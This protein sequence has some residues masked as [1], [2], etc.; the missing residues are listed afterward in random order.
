[1]QD[2]AI[3]RLN[4][5]PLLAKEGPGVLGGSP[6]NPE[7][8]ILNPASGVALLAVMSA[9]SVMIIVA[10]TFSNSVQIETRTAI[11]RKEAAQAYALAVGGV[12]AAI[13]EIAYPPPAE[14]RDAPRLWKE[15]QLVMQ[16]PYQRGTA[17]VQIVNE[18]GKLDL[19]LASR[20]Q[21]ARLFQARGLEAV[22]A[23]QLALAIDH[24]RAPA[25]AENQD[26]TALEDYYRAAG[27]RPAHARFSSVEEAL[28]LRGMARDFFYGTAL[29][30][31]G[32]GIRYEYGVGQ[33]LTIYS[34]AAQ[35]NLNYA[36]EAVLLSLPG[37]TANLV[38]SLLRE[39]AGEPFR[40]LDDV[41]QR[42]GESLPDSA[43]AFLTTQS[44]QTYSILSV[45]V[46]KGSRLRRSVR[47]VVRA[48]PEEGGE[49]HRILAWYDDAD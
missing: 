37:L 5:V 4:A 6:L 42:L 12:D 34:G 20:S 48:T 28:R 2:S 36:S 33:D 16:V 47:A 49:R 44:S 45:G 35:V 40:S 8:R 13:F 46:L 32:S 14:Q 7:S 18:A 39:R 10:L 41:T 21:L 26:F 27:Y 17:I 38:Q 1:M 22:E 3:N 24:W 19:N 15:G 43:V 9:V 25:G 31:P 11:Y 23:E 29:F 30:Q